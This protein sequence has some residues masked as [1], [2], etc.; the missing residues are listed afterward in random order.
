MN[1]I[2][3]KQI[4]KHLKKNLPCSTCNKKFCDDSIHLVSSFNDDLL[5]HFYCPFCKNQM[6]AEVSIIEQ[7][8]TTSKLNINA[9][10]G[11]IISP[12]DVLDIHNFLNRFD[13]D[14]IKLFSN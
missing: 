5:F 3:F 6:V 10:N 14:F 12:D 9:K 8:R 1:Q 11:G 4:I 7:T 2:D 13:G